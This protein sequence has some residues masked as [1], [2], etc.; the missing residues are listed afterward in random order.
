MSND[1]AADTWSSLSVNTEMYNKLDEVNS[2]VL[3]VKVMLQRLLSQKKPCAKC[4]GSN[5]Q[6]DDASKAEYEDLKE[7]DTEDAAQAKCEDQ[8]GIDDNHRK[9]S[10]INGGHGPRKKSC[11]AAEKQ[12]VVLG[13]EGY[14]EDDAESEEPQSNGEDGSYVNDSADV[15]STDDMLEDDDVVEDEDEEIE[16][17]FDADDWKDED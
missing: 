3:G 16:G 4:G 6:E 10:A 7:E 9:R 12:D 2:N 8:E 14:E 13:G 15:N 5:L 1:I 11:A 17:D